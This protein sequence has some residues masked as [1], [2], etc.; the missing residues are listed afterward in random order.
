MRK[1]IAKELNFALDEILDQ[2]KMVHLL[3][4]DMDDPYGGAFKITKGLS[5]KYPHQVHSTP[6]SEAAIVGIAS[7]MA[8]RGLIPV[9]EIMFGDFITLA[10]DQIVNHISKYRW[11]YNN[12]VEFSL[13]IRTPMGG[14]R[15]YGATHSQSLEKLFIGIPFLKIVAISYYHDVKK[16]LKSAVTEDKGPILFIENKILYSEEIRE[17]KNGLVGDFSI[18]YYPS[19]ELYP[20]IILSDNHFNETDVTLLTYGGMVS[21]V[22]NAALEMLVNEEIFAEI[23]IPSLIKPFDV[24]ILETSLKKSGRLIIIEEGT[25]S[26]GWG[27]EIAALVQE[28]YFDML[29][30][31]IRRVAA[32]DFPIPCARVLEDMV[33]PQKEDIK[34]MIEEVCK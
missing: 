2:N 8:L 1:I 11:M 27:A 4:E 14:R 33:L 23:I 10:M 30:T 21:F 29:E 16:L 13:I 5:T 20:T 26:G 25:I 6:I 24:S 15:G 7:G 22:E 31:P 12:Q 9:V 32:K 18:R 19:N 3:G 17:E 28:K 34:K